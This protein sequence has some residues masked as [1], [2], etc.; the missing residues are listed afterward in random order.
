MVLRCGS[1][2]M[3]SSL[4]MM[5]FFLTSCSFFDYEDPVDMDT[6]A[7]KVKAIVVPEVKPPSVLDDSDMVFVE[8]SVKN[9]EEK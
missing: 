6:V 1:V 2:L 8:E 9:V 7:S 3:I 5:L 4:L